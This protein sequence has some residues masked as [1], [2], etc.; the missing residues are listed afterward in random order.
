MKR[1][2]STLRDG[3]LI[4]KVN[5]FSQKIGV[6]PDD[7]IA[8]AQSKLTN[9]QTGNGGL[10]VQTSAAPT[11]TGGTMDSIK[12]HAVPVG[13]GGVTTLG[14]KYGLKKKWG[15]SLAGGLLAGAATHF[16]KGKMNE[17]KTI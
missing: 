2:Y 13:V 6:T 11:T 4:D 16:V 15:M 5:E 12:K 17:N 7:A 1:R 8:M 3:D 10:N 14:L 9:A